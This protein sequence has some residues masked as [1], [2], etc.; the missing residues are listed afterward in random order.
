[1]LRIMILMS[2]A[3]AS[4]AQTET[5]KPAP[6][7]PKHYRLDFVLKEVDGG[8][9]ANTRSYSAIAE[10][11]QAV[12]IRVSNMLPLQGAPGQYTFHEVGVYFDCGSAKEVQGQLALFVAAE[13][14]TS[15]APENPGAPGAPPLIRQNRWR[16][17]VILPLR[18]PTVLFTSDDLT[19]KRQMQLELTA[20][21]IK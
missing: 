6:A 16:S 20:I 14:S 5:P 21:P 2:M 15:V 13:I 12:Q 10:T 3:A 19:T 11:N 1:M 18:K 9:V 7:P 4:L 17:N 8:K